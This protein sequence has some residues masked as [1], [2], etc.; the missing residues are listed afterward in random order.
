MKGDLKMRHVPGHRIEIAGA[1]VID[2]LE[3][4]DLDILVGLAPI[5]GLNFAV[6]PAGSDKAV[7]A[8]KG[9]EAKKL[10]LRQRDLLLLGKPGMSIRIEQIKNETAYIN[11]RLPPDCIVKSDRSRTPEQLRDDF[12]A[13]EFGAI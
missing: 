12:E 3:L 6:V 11:Y 4:T 1:G 8:C 2:V 10:S 5:D 7:P 13:G 9:G